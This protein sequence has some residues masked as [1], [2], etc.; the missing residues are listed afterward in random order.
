MGGATA[1]R[2][3]NECFPRFA[4]CV[5]ST[6][7]IEGYDRLSHVQISHNGYFICVKMKL[8]KA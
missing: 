4:L 5:K 3:L 6:L 8:E 2:S 1:Q 7:D